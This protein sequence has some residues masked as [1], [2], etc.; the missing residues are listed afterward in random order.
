M[1][2]SRAARYSRLRLPPRRVHTSDA[3]RP[4]ISSRPFS[5]EGPASVNSPLRNNLRIGS[6]MCLGA[7]GAGALA[8]ACYD[9]YDNWRNLYPLEVRVDLKRGIGASHKGDRE[10]S[11]YYKRKAWDTAISL[12]IELFRTEPYLRI[13]GIA[14][15][16][17]GEL[18]EDGKTHEALGL[19]SEAFNLIRRS[20]AE[21]LSERERLRA[22]SIA[23][24]LGRLFETLGLPA[25]DQEKVLVWAAEGTLKLLMDVR[26]TSSPEPLDLVK[27]KL[28]NWLT[29]EDVIVPLQELGDFYGRAGRLEYAIPLYL[30]V[31][32]L[33]ISDGEAPPVD[34]CMGAHLMNNI[35]ELVARGDPTA[36]RQKAAES[37]VQQALSILQTSRKRTKEPIPICEHVLAVALFNAGMLREMAGDQNGAR[38]F[39]TAAVEQSKLSGVEEGS[40]AAKNAIDRLNTKET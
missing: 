14:I 18:E 40:T 10:S 11:A 4:C 3:Y 26:G 20:P 36:E 38:S 15:D 25:D 33:L 39:F 9:A 37:W 29:K 34:M 27:I 7:L 24:K 8:Y 31:I 23:V 32:P 21:L 17:A 12:P 1:F 22:I 19:Y 16:L 30:Q 13:T 5:T 6:L 2:T 35:A 28:P